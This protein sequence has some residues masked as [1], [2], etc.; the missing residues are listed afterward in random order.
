MIEC[1]RCGRVEGIK[2]AGFVR[3]QQR[4]FCR[5]CRY[6]FVLEKQAPAP[7]RRQTTIVDIARHLGVSPSTVS[8]ALSGRQ[9]ISPRTREEIR[10]VATE[11]QYQPN[12]LAQGLTSSKTFTI[13]VIIPNIERP[14]FASVVSGIQQVV[15]PAG[16]RVMICQSN[17]SHA[18]EVANVQALVASRVEGMLICHS[19]ETETF[20]HIARPFANG[21]PIVHFDRVC[22]EIGTAKVIQDDFGGA[23]AMVEHLLQQGYRRIAILAGP[24]K[25]LI[26]RRRLAG[27]QAAL[28]KYGLPLEEELIYHGDFRPETAR[29]ALEQWENQRPDAVFCI[30]YGNAIDLLQALR[31]RGIRVPEEMALAGFGDELLTALIEPGLT[32][33]QPYPFQIGQKA[34]RLLLEQIHHPESFVPET[35]VLKGELIVR[36]S[37][38]KSASRKK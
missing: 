17:E 4:Y 23:F 30:H 11:L 13:G 16:Y 31:E 9:D 28:E 34:A 14:F 5:D 33:I 29:R 19:I 26:S 15:S 24:E 2:R 6:Y 27:Y 25:L 32:T 7:R 1:T 38:R 21:F 18:T 22:E 8:K 20:D 35:H 10:R 36:G 12:L 37:S 3:G